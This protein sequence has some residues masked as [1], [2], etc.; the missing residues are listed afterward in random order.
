MPAWAGTALLIAAAAVGGGRFFR[1]GLR[2][3]RRLALDMHFLMTIAIVG[4]VAIGEFVEAGSIA[5]LFGLAE[6]LES[7]A[8][9]GARRSIRAL[10]DVAPPTARVWRDEV[11]R[12]VPAGDVRVGE[13]VRVRPGER[14]P[15]DGVVSE[16]VSWV[17]QSPITGESWPVEKRSGSEVYAGSANREGY[18]E[19][20]TSKA[21][22]DTTLAHILH[23]VEEAE[24]ARAPTQRFVERFARVYTPVVT[25]LAVLVIA[26]PPLLFGAPFE[27]WFVRGL[28]LLVIS[29]PCA[30]VISTPVTVVSGITSAARNGVL[31]KGGTYLEAVADVQVVAFD[32]TGTLTAGRAGVTDVVLGN[33][34]ALARGLGVRSETDLLRLAAALE[35]RSEHPIADAIRR[36]ASALPGAPATWS[37]TDFESLRGMGARARLDGRV[38]QIGRPELFGGPGPWASAIDRLGVDGKTVVCIG[39][40]REVLGVIAVRDLE[41]E[42]A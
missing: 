29:C 13:V 32:K 28:T 21:A 2:A 30:L 6:L 40:E 25:A 12:E 33:G 9:A 7:H 22:S 39:T 34:T 8:V 26:V 5:F 10:V 24:G 17:D 36:R 23:L 42:A 11:E 18:L 1:K 19:V 35:A 27:T 4:A 15:V 20:R 31:I 37:V 3:A 41:R 38:V 14:V 16:G